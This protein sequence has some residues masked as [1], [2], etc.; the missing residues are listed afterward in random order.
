[1]SLP[2]SDLVFASLRSRCIAGV[3]DLAITLIVVVPLTLAFSQSGLLVGVAL[4]IAA[5]AAMEANGGRT[6]GKALMH[7]RVLQLDGTPCTRLAAIV[8]NVFRVIDGFPGIYLIAVASIGGSKRKQR[9]GDQAAGTSVYDDRR[10]RLG[11]GASL[12]AMSATTTGATANRSLL[13]WVGEWEGVLTPQRVVWCDGSAAQRAELESALV[14]AGTFMPLDPTLRPDSFL[15]RSDPRDVARVEERTYIASETDPGPTNNWREPAA[16]R[17]EL[18][19]C[20][21]GA[22]RGRTLY[23]VPFSMGPVGAPS[24][25]IGV[26][27]TDSAYAAISMESM[28]RVEGALEALGVDGEFVRCVHSIG[29][30]LAPGEADVAWPCDP[31]RTAIAHFPETRE[32]WSYGSGYGGNALLGKKC[33]ALRIASVIA[34]DEGWLAEHM[35]I[36]KLTSP[37]G[38][39]HYIAGAFPSA[40]G[41]TNL[42]MLV[43]ALPG[44]KVET[45]GD[46]IAW[47]RFGA[48]GRLYAINPE[49]G[50]FGVAPGT[51]MA[52]NPNA[53]RTIERST[54]FT[55]TALTPEGDVWWERMTVE[56]PARAI[57]WLGEPWTPASKGPAAHPNAR[58]TVPASRCPSMAPEWQDPAGVPISAIL[59]GGRR[60]GTVPLVSE[61][62]SWQHGVFLG[63]TMAS[64]TTAAAAGAVGELRRDPFAMLPFC[65][66]HMGDYMA[67]WLQ[68]G[69]S[70]DASLL[71]RIFQVNW[72]RRAEDRHFLW[73]GFGENAR[74]LAWIHGRCQGTAD[75]IDTPIGLLPALGS[76]DVSG[77]DLEPGALDE[78]LAFDPAAWR[79]EVP[80]IEE[81]LGLFGERLPAAVRAELDELRAR[82]G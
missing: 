1:M 43:P 2:N 69:A 58:F 54:I 24:A 27:L 77:L 35:L 40:C 13:A 57:D 31:E 32:I 22:M 52:T 76:I 73:P 29:A 44:W 66:Y 42:A 41:K 70:A 46:D 10:S 33:L 18:L 80:L 63:A 60:A 21:R 53:M 50:F 51:G 81:H 25:K 17:A 3:V 34:R 82:L 19:A 9:L 5:F 78:L 26:Q 61:A 45:I 12:G 72:F 16:L 67:H 30:P 47:M 14:D 56:P 71:P 68:L 36:L 11:G 8:R 6:P 4:V 48:D 7:I 75:A 23:V 28:T 38:V 20:Y 55:N 65:G 62:R 37:T 74:V 59:F 79:A 15:A 64:E 49:Y 39:A